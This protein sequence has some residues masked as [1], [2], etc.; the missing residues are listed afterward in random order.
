VKALR[1]TEFALAAA[2]TL[3]T[4]YAGAA[5]KTVVTG[6]LTFDIA[7]LTAVL[8]TVSGAI[9]AHLE[10]SRIEY[11]IERYSAAARRLEDEKQ[12]FDKAAADP[13][14]WSKFVNK[15][16]DIIAA[17]NTSWIAKWSEERPH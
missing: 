16:E 5:G 14:D 4:V 3:I 10:S 15:C 2:A 6:E 8:T 9:L 17:E 12:Y 7:A 11:L 1:V 13:Q